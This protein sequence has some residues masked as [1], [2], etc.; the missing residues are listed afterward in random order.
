MT[1]TDALRQHATPFYRYDRATLV[2]SW[3][4]LRGCLPD[5]VDV[6]FSMKANPNVAMIGVL[7]ALGSGAEV[8]SVAELRTAMRVGVSSD[9]IVFLGPGKSDADLTECVVSG[10]LAVVVESLSELHRLDTIARAMGTRQ[11]VLL[12]INPAQAV[13]GARLAM[14]G[15]PRQFGIDEGQA[16]AAAPG[17]TALTGV[18]VAGVHVYLG[19]RIL[20]AHVVVENTRHALTISER[21]AAATGQEP[22]VVDVGG[23][24]GV[25][26]FTGEQPLDLAA[27]A[28]GVAPLVEGYLARHPGTR[29]L[30]ESGRF[31]SAPAGQ[32]VVAVR[33]VK[34]SH[35]T[36][37]AVT[38]GGTH[39]HMAAVGVGSPVRRNFPVT[40]LTATGPTSPWTVTGVLCT[41]ND[42]IA[43]DVDLPD[44]A[45]GDLLAVEMSGAYG[46]TASPGL[47]LSHGHPAEV[48]VDGDTHHVVRRA[49]TPDDV[50]RQHVWHPEL[51]GSPTPRK[52]VHA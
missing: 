9:D 8:S 20:D 46:P 32:Y 44:L 14:G 11:R 15:K 41:P 18:D 43:K 50:V 33:D 52:E 45:P 42:T 13:A 36:R 51:A 1:G 26:Y 28:A 6:L 35:G 7:S 21:L 10:V 49:D 29:V 2:A 48:M 47:F 16:L 22:T 34:T 23:G 19:T 4:S 40:S 31:L 30:L 39:H 25:P 17:L 24:F 37:F 3:D 38:D 5:A 12:R 27:V